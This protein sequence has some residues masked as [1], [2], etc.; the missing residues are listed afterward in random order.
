MSLNDQRVSFVVVVW[1]RMCN[2]HRCCEV[3]VFLKVLKWFR[4]ATHTVV[5]A[6]IRH[7]GRTPP[8]VGHADGQHDNGD[9]CQRP[10]QCDAPRWV[11]IRF[12]VL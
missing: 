4:N 12:V 7:V 11:L 2:F 10:A 5:F 3:F 6:Y 9:H 8:D 1:R